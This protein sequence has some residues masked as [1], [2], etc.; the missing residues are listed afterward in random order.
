MRTIL[1]IILVAVTALVLKAQDPLQTIVVGDTVE[2]RVTGAHA[3]IQWQQSTDSLTWTDMVGFTDS[4]AIFLATT[5]PTNKKYYRAII[6]DA[7]CSIATPVYSSIIRHRIIGSITAVQIGDMFRGGIVF[8]TDGTGHGLIAPQQDQSTYVQW[9]C[10]GTSIPGASSLTDGNTNTT[11]IYN[12]CANRPIAASICYDLVLN[13][14]N[15][16]FLPA[17]NQLNYLYQQRALVGGFINFSYWSSSEYDESIAWVQGFSN[18]IQNGGNKYYYIYVRCARSFSSS[19]NT[20]ATH[21]IATVSGQPYTA[22]IT[23]QPQTQNKCLGSSV[24]F[25]ISA[26]GT[27]PVTFQWKKDGID[28]SGATSNTYTK[29]ILTLADKGI[30]TCEVTNL[31]RSVLSD[32][33][34]LKVIQLSANAG[35]DTRICNGQS[36]TLSASCSSNHP[37]ES[38]NYSYS[39]SPTTGLSS[40]NMYNP[41]TSAT[42]TTNYNVQ[43]TDQ[44]GCT[45]TDAVN[46]LV[47]NVFQN[48]EICLVSVDTIVWKNKVIWEGTPGVGTAKYWI[49]REVVTNVYNCVGEVQ[50]GSPTFFIDVASNPESHSDRYKITV[51]DTCNNESAKSAYHNS[52]EL[53]VSVSGST[54]GLV[55]TEYETEDGSYIPDQY[56]IYKGPTPQTM[57]LLTTVTGSHNTYN[58]VNVFDLQYYMI[59]AHRNCNTDPAFSNKRSNGFENVEEISLTG[60]ILISPNPMTSTTILT[61]P[62]FNTKIKEPL[63]IMDI[64]GKVVR[65]EPIS[66]SRH[67]EFISGSPLAHI[68][69]ERGDLKS[70]IYFVELKS[71][72]TYRGKLIIE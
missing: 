22:S 65:S 39:W 12:N 7:L 48:E 56:Y 35:T 69:I 62:N 67:P 16:W 23:T 54:M 1:T 28:I 50:Y 14:Y 11:A 2:L 60:T 29:S 13:G 59:G 42:I 37:A 41:N 31:C 64:T 6:T 10:Y 47:Q 27:A 4:V 61:I 24:A 43:A 57:T 38:G 5:S 44:I 36:T 72:R 51:I 25:S 66:P 33:A 70:G 3:S 45:A 20:T 17:K 52:M 8:Y 46:V 49:Y 58:D 19:D 21:S 63:Q 34:E 18:G 32:N 30:Y 53:V 15:D 68:I 26:T 55:W 9:G 71:D 40:S